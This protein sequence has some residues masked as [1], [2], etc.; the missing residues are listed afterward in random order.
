MGPWQTLP[1]QEP[2]DGELCWVRLN[3]WFGAPFQAKWV[4]STKTFNPAADPSF[5]YPFWT[6]SRWATA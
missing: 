3:Y 4:K 6:I 2:A 1:L 5:E